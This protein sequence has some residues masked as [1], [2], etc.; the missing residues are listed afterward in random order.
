MPNDTLRAILI[1]AFI[2]SLFIPLIAGLY[3]LLVENKFHYVVQTLLKGYAA[4]AILMFT[5]VFLLG[6]ILDK[7]E[8]MNLTILSLRVVMIWVIGIW[9]LTR[10]ADIAKQE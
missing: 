10:E 3:L 7:G 9:V 2:P 8:A 6:V 4:Y 5:C 1:D